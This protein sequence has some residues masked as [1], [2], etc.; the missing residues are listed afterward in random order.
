METRGFVLLKDEFSSQCTTINSSSTAD[1][2]VATGQSIHVC[3]GASRGAR[4]WPLPGPA[5]QVDA[6]CSH[7]CGTKCGQYC[8]VSTRT[9]TAFDAVGMPSPDSI[10]LA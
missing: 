9:L 3:P 10:S 2:I 8:C 5:G 4:V 6:A 7:K 1:K